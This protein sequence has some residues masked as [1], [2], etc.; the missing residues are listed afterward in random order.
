MLAKNRKDLCFGF[1]VLGIGV[2][3][4]VLALRLPR[5]GG[6]DSATVPLFLAVL[7]TALGVIQIVG[8]VR[9]TFRSGNERDKKP[10]PEGMNAAPGKDAPP[11]PDYKTVAMTAVLIFLYVALLD[12]LGF[13]VMSALYL[14]VQI[15]VLKPKCEKA[16]RAGYAAISVAT[17]TLVYYLFF[18]AFDIML[19]H[20]ELWYDLGVN[21]DWSPFS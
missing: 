21:M 17:A 19:P 2:A 9:G 11:G 12:F 14:F 16:N 13:M 1:I 15:S 10:G 8:A 3:Y 6:I 18:W 5:G 20:G 7:M 4:L